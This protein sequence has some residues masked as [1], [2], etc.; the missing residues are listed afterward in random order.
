MR[1]FLIKTAVVVLCI[2]GG[3]LQSQE[4]TYTQKMDSLMQYVDK[5]QMTTPILYDRVF[6]FT[7][8]DKKTPNNVDYNYFIQAWS[9][10]HRASNNPNFISADELKVLAKESQKNNR[11]QL[12]V[13]H[14]KYNYIDYG[15]PQSPNLVFENGFFRN[16]AGK[17]P[18]REKE[19]TMV[20]PLVDKITSSQVQ[21]V[22]DKNSIAKTLN[23]T[24]IQAIQ[25]DF[26]NGQM[27]TISL[28]QNSTLANGNSRFSTQ[29]ATNGT[30]NLTFKIT[31]ADGVQKTI[32][33]KMEVQ[34]PELSLAVNRKQNNN[35]EDFT[36]AKG[37]NSTIP[38]QGYNEPAA[39]FGKLEYSI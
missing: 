7:N 26:G 22:L 29:Y 24:P 18:F 3:L 11:I 16:V 34:A 28:T 36:G 4:R 13:I 10:L 21:F 23:S 30:K 17:N 20:V 37:I 14:L 35:R 38:F 27:Q 5:S 31:Y 33:Q 9:E 1:T 32:S 15:T 25:V 8:L 39:R 12:G 2:S 19:I 6:S